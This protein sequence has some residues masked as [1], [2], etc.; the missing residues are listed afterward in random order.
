MSASPPAPAVVCFGEALVDLLEE[1]SPS[2]AAPRFVQHAGGAPANVAVA[3]ARLGGVAAF[4]GMLGRD[5][6]GDFLLHEMQAANVLVDCVVRTNKAR[7]AIS[8]VTLDAD[9]ERH[10]SFY[11][12]PAADLLFRTEHFPG[13]CFRASA[14]H[15]CSNTLTEEPVAAATLSGMER[16]RAEGA[17]ISFDMNLRREL[18][19]DGIDPRGPVWRAL[20]EADL[21]KLSQS[22]FQFLGSESAG[23]ADLLARLWAGRA[24]LVL[25]TDGAAPVRYFTRDGAGEIETFA[26]GAIDTTGAGDAFVGGLLYELQRRRIGRAEFDGLAA[27][28]DWLAPV[29]RFAAACGALAVT[30]RGAFSAMPDLGAVRALLRQAA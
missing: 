14:F 26:V 5:P 7:T 11:R 22:E 24:R 17:L 6:F 12:A 30:H 27:A 2:G 13:A 20:A 1:R 10:F 19:P 8:F 15:A 18:W 16:A 9:G 21:V 23:E 3:V 29:V 4:I 28:T 25:V